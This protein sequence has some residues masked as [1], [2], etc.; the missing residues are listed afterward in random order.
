MPAR[1]TASLVVVLA[2]TAC[3]GG[4]EETTTSTGGD[5]TTTTTLRTASSTTVSTTSTSTTFPAPIDTAR[6][7]VGKGDD[8]VTFQEDGDP[9]SGPSSF[10]V[11]LDGSV[12]IADTMAA[13]R[14]EPRLLHFDRSGSELA[15]LALAPFEVAAVVDVTTNGTDLAV[16]DVFIARDRYRVL[17]LTT[18]GELLHEI[19]IPVG[20]RLEDGL[21]GLVWDDAGLLLEFELGTRYARVGLDGDMT[22]GV[23][24]SFGGLEARIVP[25]EGR[26]SVINLGEVSFE[27]ERPSDLGGVALVGVAPDGA[28]VVVLDEVD[29]SGPA[30][31]VHQ[32]VRRYS[33]DGA[34][35]T[36]LRVDVGD[37]FVDIARPWEMGADG[38]ILYLAAHSQGVTVTPESDLASP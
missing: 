4:T 30:I 26:T 5:V 10:A 22:P 19:A 16:L 17:V 9:P 7:T 20:Y 15:K 25:G 12:V 11:L 29:L 18:G 28:I 31:R 35:L 38:A 34:L 27:V 14:G 33:S 1:L 37:Q 3:A 13:S 2:L 6:F 32:H 23:F 36:E 21:T 24:P 8:G